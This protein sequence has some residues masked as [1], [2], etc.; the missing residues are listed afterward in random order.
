MGAPYSVSENF[1]QEVTEMSNAERIAITRK[2]EFGF[3][4]FNEND[5][6]LSRPIKYVKVRVNGKI[7][8]FRP[9]EG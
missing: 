5:W 4:E 3:D 1:I 9:K 7:R 2:Q 8:V 6:E